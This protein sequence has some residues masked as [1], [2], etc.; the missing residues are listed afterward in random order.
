MKNYFPFT[1]YDFYAYITAGVIVIAGLD[2]SLFGGLLVN[3][4]EWTV[5]QGVFWVMISY[6]VG[7]LTAGPSSFFL[8][9]KLTN[10]LLTAPTMV[11]LGLRETGWFGKLL[12]ALF[13]REYSAFPSVACDEIQ[14]KLAK[15]LD[16]ER[17]ALS[18]HETIFHTAFVDA[19]YEVSSDLRMNQFMNLYGMCRNVAFSFLLISLLLIFKVSIHSNPADRWLLAGSLVMAIGM[20]GRFLKFY[21][22]YTREAFRAFG[23]KNA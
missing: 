10:K 12:G 6:L 19:R 7:H 9:Q 5:V 23:R 21:A 14:D 13:A 1:D 3:R 20:Y 22:C 8:E 17:S 15:K 4:T 11:I 2:Y 16:C 18:D